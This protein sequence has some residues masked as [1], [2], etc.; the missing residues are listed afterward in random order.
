MMKIEYDEEFAVEFATVIEQYK[1]QREDL[2]IELTA[3]QLE[4]LDDFKGVSKRHTSPS[5][6]RQSMTS[7]VKRLQ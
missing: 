6:G 2:P 4:A 7:S 1:R 3:K 5:F